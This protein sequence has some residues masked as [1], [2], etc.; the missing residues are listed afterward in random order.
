MGFTAPASAAPSTGVAI[1]EVYG[2]NG[3]TNLYN[4][5]F[6]E[7]TNSSASTVNVTGWSVQYRSA[8]SGTGASSKVDLTGTIPA[9]GSLLVG[10]AVSTC[11]GA[12]TNTLPTPDAEGT[13]MNLSGTAGVVILSNENTLLTNAVIG[14]GDVRDNA[15][16]VDLVGYGSTAN[17][18]ENAATASSGPSAAPSNTTTLKRTAADADD[19]SAEFAASAPGT[20]TNAAP[21][22]RAL[23]A[24]DPGDKT[25]YVNKSV[26]EFTLEASG[27][28]APYTW[29]ATGVPTGLTI[30]PD[31]L[32]SGTPTE[33]GTFTVTATAK[34]AVADTADTTFDIVVAE[35]PVKPLK[36]IPEIQGTGASTPLAGQDVSV[37]GVVTATFPDGG[38]NGFVIETPRYDPDADTT[39]GASDGLF[40]YQ[41]SSPS[42]TA[43]V[44]DYV[45]ILNG[46]VSEAF[47]ATQI[48]V[49]NA[50]FV[51][52]RDA[53][54][55]DAVAPAAVVPGTDCVQGACPAGAALDALR[56]AHEFEAFLPAGPHT[57]TDSYSGG[58]GSSAMRGEFKLAM[59]S[60][61]P[62]Y[63]PLELA[64]PSQ[65]AL[66][67]D[68]A[69][70]NDAHG[71]I[72][73]DGAT[74][75]YNSSTAYPW[76]TL[77]NTVRSGA[78]ATFVKPVVLDYRYGGWRLQPANR[79][80]AGNDG[81]AWVQFEQN[82]PAAP[83][84]VM[85]DEG[86]LKI[87][88]FN[89]LNYFV[90]PVD[91]WVANGGD[92]YPGTN[93]TCST[94]KDRGGVPLTANT[95]TWTDPRTDPPSL[96][97][98]LG[99]RGAATQVSINRQQVKE[100][101]AINTMDADV[102][103]LEEVENAI[104]L[105]YSDRDAALKVLVNALNASY[106][107]AHPGED[108]AVLGKRWAFVPTPRAQ[109]QP[110]VQE[111]DVIRNAFIFNPRTV[112]TVGVSQIL[113][114]APAM[115]NAREPLAQAFKHKDGT[116]D[117]AFIVIT[118][119]FKSKGGPDDP[120]TIAGTD[121]EDT[122]NGA[123]SYN[124]DRI[125]QAKALDAFA[126]A[127]SDDKGIAPVFM[128]GDYN[129]YSAE[130][131]IATLEGLGWN[132]LDADNGETSYFYGGLA[133]SLDHV[134]ANDAAQ[135]LVQGA[136]IWPINANEPIYYE[137]SR[138][139][140]NV[141]P[142]YDQT[143]F[144][145][146]DHNPEIVGIKAPV[147]AAPADVDTVQ[148]LASNDFHGRLLDDPASASAGAAAMAGA[149]KGLRVENP[150]TAFVMAGDI[151]GASTFE[152][153]IQNDKPT[154][155]AMNEAGLEV[156]AAGNHE[157][158]KGYDDLMNRIMSAGA[159]DDG[160][161]WPYIAANVRDAST[162]DYALKSN[163][164]DGNFAHANG[165]TW[166]KDFS[167]LNSDSGIR[168]GFVGAVTEDLGSLVAPSAIEGLEITSI[169]EEVNAAADTLKVD[170]CGGEPCDLVIELVHEGAPSPSCAT[171]K[172]D[173]DSTFGRIVHGTSTKVDA[174]ISG[175]THLKYNCR[176]D[177]A[178]KTFSNGTDYKRPV[179]SAGQYGSYLNQLEFDFAPDT[180]DLVGIRQHVLAMKD[181]DED[182]P[183]ATIVAA[184]VAVADEK[185]TQ[186]LGE[187]EG[188]FKRARRID[189]VSGTV[190]NRGGE[191]TL[192]NLVAEIQREKT[193]A[194]IGVMNPG[195]LRDDLIGT[196]DGPGPVTYREAANVQPFA[197]TLVTVDLTGTQL[198]LLLEQQW[199]RDP[200]NNIPSRPFLRLGTS[201]GFSWTEDSSRSEGDRITGMWLNGQM[202][203]M[204]TIYTVSANSFI[205]TGGDNF[206]ALTLGTNKQDTG[207]TDLQ[208][209]V[210]YLA[211]HAQASPLPVDHAQHA[212]GARV[213]T[214]P[215]SA[216]DTVT[217]AVDSLAMTGAGDVTDAEVTISRGANDLGTFPVDTA[218]PTTPFD[219]PGAA[220]VSFTLP[221]GLAVGT[222]WFTL[223]GGTTGTVAHI[224]V[225]VVDSRADSTVTGAAA[226]ITIGG[227]G[228]VEVTVT[229]TTA[230]G[231]VAL[232]DGQVKLGEG[233]L[234]GGATA[235]VIPAN[236]LAVGA[237][238]LSLS[239]AGDTNVKAASGTVSVTVK[240]KPTPQPTAT[241]V[242]GTDVTLQWSKAASV[243]VSVSPA[244]PGTVELYDGATKLGEATVR[245]GGSAIIPLAARSL[246]VGVHTLV[247]KYTGS[248]GYAAS[249]STVTVTVDRVRAKVKAVKPS[250][251]DAGDKAKIKVRVDTVSDDVTG[252]V[253]IILKEVGGS[254]KRKLTR[255]LENGKVVAKVKVPR[256]GRYVVKAKY[257]GDAHTLRGTDSTHLRVN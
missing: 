117:D 231:V 211:A 70:Y 89:M 127:V 149:V 125:R 44:G 78:E 198:K 105:G 65:T 191:S 141:T 169:V 99:P 216:G 228:S 72:L 17:V 24:A 11:T 223:T 248:A 242:S 244:A 52:F 204:A 194:D 174:I 98:D 100:V 12:C 124:G 42:Y 222:Q 209:T 182:A 18:F 183:T 150:D 193:K 225:A 140:Y 200:D 171:I 51:E 34:D 215:F 207:F 123:G 22:V 165:A 138:F 195:G 85:G 9:G 238:A 131:P 226:D 206:R 249:R 177:V 108:S 93:R 255:T 128:T 217:V 168:V 103:S 181:F 32:V 129:A 178:G 192:G 47:G 120:T 154:I 189:P 166:W 58:I 114:N 102:M 29:A 106:D 57:V 33:T 135:D 30:S 86:S 87:A 118:N 197:N 241:T 164:T 136:T 224:P 145:S 173:Q 112:K 252:R 61:E 143:A 199:Q 187:V 6:V 179:V 253:R 59:G 39:P 95:C 250:A 139:N 40:V 130:D 73:D 254:F 66:R 21:V 247:V 233:P 196:G 16:V 113:V 60:V 184:A 76:L 31:G 46:R 185:G 257:L 55:E 205:A 4:Q 229:P 158:D 243:A 48:T 110:T 19:N 104:K 54:A 230:T 111:Q 180:N 49:T 101:A 212:V 121:N 167:G 36:T 122:G 115:R 81:R 152:S 14:A 153:F 234:A 25:V 41:G 13:S 175:H 155:D 69:D 235:I 144:R 53:A 246:E 80:P 213:P 227:A 163:R 63:I 1:T 236:A 126:K 190:E 245:G 15:K 84:N 27:G 97:G 160:A 37:E 176:V 96:L 133:G 142:L 172:S 214:G 23:S 82:R 218:L 116:R 88:T 28:T 232:F 251:V 256:S 157:F 162:G 75:S 208:A 109:A 71:V 7:L 2:S 147:S 132:P 94:Y 201:K 219:T 134:F 56:E 170:G 43:T 188:P 79:I 74:V 90:H 62:L 137:Y 68:I 67:Q 8:T 20:P 119:H 186:Q 5:D 77:T 38:I 156:S 26:Q 91:E 240:A 10:G 151:V 107:A 148:V 146:S 159:E 220:T 35:L 3:A 203:E 161:S 45:T 50:D 83:D 92:A 64:T 202:I 239:Y 210:D 221:Q 237:H